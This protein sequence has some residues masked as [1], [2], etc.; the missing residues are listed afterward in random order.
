MI[1]LQR[2]HGR[3]KKDYGWPVAPAA[4]TPVTQL[5]LIRL[6]FVDQAIKKDAT[7][8]SVE[9]K[10]HTIVGNPERFTPPW[11]GLRRRQRLKFDSP[12]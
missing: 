3:V 7:A 8:C 6:D 11:V 5:V 2:S 12:F 10:P 1:G 4:D 9:N